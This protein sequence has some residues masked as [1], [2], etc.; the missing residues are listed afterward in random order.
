M[1][2]F[3][4]R[5]GVVQSNP[6]IGVRAPK[7]P[8]HLPDFLPIDEM[9]LLLDAPDDKTA[10]GVRDRAILELL[11]AGGFRVS[12]LAGLDVNDVDRKQ[13]QAR[14]LGKGN[15]ERI[16]PVGSKALAALTRWLETRPTMFPKG[17]VP[18]ALFLNRL[19]GRLT[20]RSIARLIDKAVDK[21]ALARHVH[22]HALRHTFA[23]HLLEGGA[24]LRDIQ[25]LLGHARLST[26]QKY[27]HVTLTRLQ[28]V[29]DRAHPR[30]KRD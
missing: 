1:Y 5:R 8:K 18:T 24:D 3:W 13:G 11:Y 14:V 28:E 27:T 16:V 15:K 19:G 26:T 12:E 21:V 2:R 7:R 29:Y 10:L 30:A 4:K 20:V 22:P 23:T 6:W 17:K 25:E 9:F